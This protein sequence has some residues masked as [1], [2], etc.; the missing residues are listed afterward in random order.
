MFNLS[1]KKSVK[2]DIENIGKNDLQR[3]VDNIKSLKLNPF[4]PAVKKIKKGKESYYR[5]R[6][7][8]FRIGYKVDTTNKLI[9]IIFIRRR[10]EKT[11]Y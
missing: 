8:D 2:K 11:Y 9:E 3:I 1:V 10:S 7:G 4:P 6:Q 5:L